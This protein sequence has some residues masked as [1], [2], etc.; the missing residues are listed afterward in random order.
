[1][2]KLKF[3]PSVKS[4]DYLYTFYIFSHCGR[5]SGEDEKCVCV[6]L[7]VCVCV[8]KTLKLIAE[9]LKKILMFLDMI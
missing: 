3:L 5:W 9:I 1:M 6:C 7:C 2:S 8:N 4:A